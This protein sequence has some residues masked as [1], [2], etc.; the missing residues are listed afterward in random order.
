MSACAGQRGIIYKSL[1]NLPN[2][3]STTKAILRRVIEMT[4]GRNIAGSDVL[5]LSFYRLALSTLLSLSMLSYEP[6]WKK[7]MSMAFHM[8]LKAC[9]LI[10]DCRQRHTSS[11]RCQ[12]LQPANE[13]QRLHRLRIHYRSR[14]PRKDWVKTSVTL[15]PLLVLP[16]GILFLS[17]ITQPAPVPVL[18]FA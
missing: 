3:F 8:L 16:F 10:M 5:M 6:S 9:G 2:P 13:R 17:P 11:C 4:G 12:S 15:F 18:P 7:G 14:L 1:L